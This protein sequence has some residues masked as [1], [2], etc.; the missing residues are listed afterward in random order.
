MLIKRWV[1][2]A[3]LIFLLVL[4]IKLGIEVT[5]FRSTVKEYE[6]EVSNAVV[7]IIFFSMLWISICNLLYE[8]SYIQVPLN[9]IGQMEMVF[10]AFCCSL[11]P[12]NKIGEAVGVVH[13]T[14]RAIKNEL[15]WFDSFLA[16]IVIYVLI[17][18]I[19]LCTLTRFTIRISAYVI[20]LFPFAFIEKHATVSAVLITYEVITLILLPLEDLF[21]V[22][23]YKNNGEGMAEEKEPGTKDNVG[24]MKYR[25]LIAFGICIV[26]L[27]ILGVIGKISSW[28]GLMTQVF[29]NDYL[30]MLKVKD[31][32]DNGPELIALLLSFSLG[33]I[34]GKIVDRISESLGGKIMSK[35]NGILM[36]S[37]VCILIVD[38][39]TRHMVK[40]YSGEVDPINDP[41]LPEWVT[42]PM[43]TAA[44]SNTFL[45]ILLFV[46]AF[47]ILIA[48]IIWWLSKLYILL[49][50]I[51]NGVVFI[52]V[53]LF[54]D[55][56]L[57]SID[58]SAMSTL[59][60]YIVCLGLTAISSII[61]DNLAVPGEVRDRLHGHIFDEQNATS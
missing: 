58:F 22:F 19:M 60:V 48:L 61:S 40:F 12:S 11:I 56:M 31:N 16:L 52:S 5:A 57:P 6:H 54:F 49:T 45:R 46:F 53:I 17:Y 26:I 38:T 55:S 35:I 39:I 30:E 47:L 27:V 21:W 51:I 4:C 29:S 37:I 50:S 2:I 14:F 28:T 43:R 23:A 1:H 3:I 9:V 7:C 15:I 42:A 18:V 44:P 32:L 33:S 24:I 8:R 20:I 13:S 34:I 36:Q 10:L 25:S 59:W 41:D